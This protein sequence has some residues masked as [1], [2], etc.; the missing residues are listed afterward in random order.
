MEKKISFKKNI[1]IWAFDSRHFTFLG[2]LTNPIERNNDYPVALWQTNMPT[3]EKTN[4]KNQFINDKLISAQKIAL[5]NNAK[6]LIT[7][8]GTLNNNFNLNFKSK[9]R[10]LAGGFRNSK[11]GLRSSLLGYQIGDKTYSSFIDK[12]RLVPL[13]RKFQDS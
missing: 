7:P 11:N 3:R 13:G 6:L 5:S 2:G 12:H 9:I 10:M 1:L 8:E 4:F